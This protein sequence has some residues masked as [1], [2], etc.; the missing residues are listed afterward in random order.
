[1][2]YRKKLTY[3]YPVIQNWSKQTCTEDSSDESADDDVVEQVASE[4]ESEQELR[5]KNMS[6]PSKPKGVL[7]TTFYGVKNPRAKTGKKWK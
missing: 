2:T 6:K 5:D 1:M 4:K 3:T 7:K